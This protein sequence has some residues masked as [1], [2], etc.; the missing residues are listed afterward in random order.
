MVY[1][2]IYGRLKHYSIVHEAILQTEVKQ[3][4]SM[5]D[6]ICLVGFG[7]SICMPAY[8]IPVITLLESVRDMVT[9]LDIH[10]LWTSVN[11]LQLDLLSCLL[12]GSS[13]TV[14]A[15]QAHYQD[16]C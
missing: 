1:Q 14:W 7:Y 4:M 6:P 3:D 12:K 2:H 5:L 15:V 10:R 9:S 11:G 13:L 8:L 16:H